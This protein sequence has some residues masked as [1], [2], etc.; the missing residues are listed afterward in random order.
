MTKKK[1][2]KVHINITIDEDLD[3]WLDK[4]AGEFRMNKSQ[5]INNIILEGKGD[6]GLMR[7]TGVLGAAKVIKK[8]KEELLK[9]K[10]KRVATETG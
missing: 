4:T 9:M 10:R 1:V 5:L 2:P 3:R 6:I 7:G 8:L